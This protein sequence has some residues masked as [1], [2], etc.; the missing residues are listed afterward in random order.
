MSLRSIEEDTQ[1]ILRYPREQCL[2][3]EYVESKKTVDKCLR[4][5][6]NLDLS[7]PLSAPAAFS[8]SASAI[9]RIC[10]LRYQCVSVL[11]IYVLSRH[12][13]EWRKVTMYEGVMGLLTAEFVVE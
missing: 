8:Q 7:S 13:E 6:E 3:S 4:P 9:A 5:G 11:A 12:S 10:L 2:L 1:D